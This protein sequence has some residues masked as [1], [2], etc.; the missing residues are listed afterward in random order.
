[1]SINSGGQKLLSGRTLAV[2]NQR[3][4]RGFKRQ[5]PGQMPGPLPETYLK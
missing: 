2:S 5:R 4:R 3:T 1:M